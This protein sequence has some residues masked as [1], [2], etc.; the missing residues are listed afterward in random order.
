[1]SSSPTLL[2]WYGTVALLFRARRQL[3]MLTR[4]LAD[5]VLCLSVCLSVCLCLSQV[6]VLSKQLNK[7]SWSMVRELP[8]SYPTQLQGNSG[9]F[10]NKGTSLWNFVP[11]SGLRKFCFRISIV[12]TWYRL[13]STKVDAQSTINWTVVGQL[14]LTVP[15]SSDARPL[16][17]NRW[18]SSAV[19]STMSSRGSI[20]R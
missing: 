15:P 20:S 2:M 4:V 6:G 10:K 8:S 5:V 14:K 3:A 9:I 7:S 11:N 18:S 13:R 17:H 16:Y 19:H 1:M 12:K